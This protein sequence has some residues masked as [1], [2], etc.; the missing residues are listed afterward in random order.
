MQH[1]LRSS[2]TLKSKGLHTGL[3]LTATF[4]PAPAGSGLRLQR[5][6]LPGQPVVEALAENV[7]DTSRGTVVASGDVRISTI[8]H[9]MA[10]LYAAGVDNCTVQL[11][12][13]EMPILDGS[14]RYF[15]QFILKVGLENQ[16]VPRQYLELSEPVSFS[17][18]QSGSRL[19]MTPAEDF[20][21]EATIEFPSRFIQSQSARLDRLSDFAAEIAEARTFVFVREIEPLLQMG[22]IKGGDLDNAIVIYEHELPQE[23]LDRLAD[24]LG[25]SRRDATQLGY[26]N[27]RPLTWPNEP[28]RHKLLDVIGDM[29]LVGRRLRGHIVAVRPGHTANNRFA[30]LLRAEI[31]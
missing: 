9:A 11:D 20:S 18:E 6:D 13:P 5:T 17:D 19:V 12:G 29:A 31:K 7:V 26:I 1:T 2:F 14:S 30:R 8:E 27:A 4:L 25:V 15:L 23:R 3:D 10:A 22:L 21:V 24:S 16:G 28:A